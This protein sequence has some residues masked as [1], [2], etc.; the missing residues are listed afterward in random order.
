M[1]PRFRIVPSSDLCTRRFNTCGFLRGPENCP[2]WTLD[3]LF[4][5]A[6]QGKASSME[7]CE[8]MW[9]LYRQF[10]FL[11]LSVDLLGNYIYSLRTDFVDTFFPECKTLQTG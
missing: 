9:L 6:R 11:P 2:Q 4:S 3:L 10:S 5:K 7:V 8:I 1:I